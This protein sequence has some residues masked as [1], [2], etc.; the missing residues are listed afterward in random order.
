MVLLLLVVP[1]LCSILFI[2]PAHNVK[3]QPALPVTLDSAVRA[4]N[5]TG[6]CP[7]KMPPVLAFGN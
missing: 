5:I 6:I 2:R 4:L 3:E 1:F 7:G